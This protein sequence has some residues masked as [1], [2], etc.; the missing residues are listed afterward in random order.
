MVC[1]SGTLL[2]EIPVQL[3][4][5]YITEESPP[6]QFNS[7]SCHKEMCY[8]LYMLSPGSDS[9]RCGSVEWV[10][11]LRPS[12]YWPRSEYSASNFQMKM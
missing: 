4:G 11:A 3:S 2:Q 1:G 7:P 9:I 10:W 6:F 12:S 5:S 8:V